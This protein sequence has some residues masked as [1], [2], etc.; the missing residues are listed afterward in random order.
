MISCSVYRDG[1]TLNGGGPFPDYL[2]LSWS[3]KF[4]TMNN[5]AWVLGKIEVP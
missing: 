4:A 3:H 5:M 2:M 1:D